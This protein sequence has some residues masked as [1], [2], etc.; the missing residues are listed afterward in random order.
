MGASKRSFAGAGDIGTG[1]S[2][3]GVEDVGAGSGPVE[4]VAPC[5]GVGDG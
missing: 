3:D 4:G 2:E 1:D 5:V